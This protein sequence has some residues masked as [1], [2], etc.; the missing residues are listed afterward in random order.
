VKTDLVVDV[1]ATYRKPSAEHPLAV[2]A[3][4]KA[5]ATFH[6]ENETKSAG[7]SSK[8]AETTTAAATPCSSVLL[9]SSSEFQSDAVDRLNMWRDNANVPAVTVSSSAALE[10]AARALSVAPKMTRNLPAGSQC[11]TAEAKAA[12]SSASIVV[13]ANKAMSKEDISAEA[14][15]DAM[16]WGKAGMRVLNPDTTGEQEERE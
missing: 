3:G 8:P 14:A 13:M 15:V 11:T 1:T 10:D 4:Q 7:K 2:A 16:V 6:G 12:L 9:Q 5:S